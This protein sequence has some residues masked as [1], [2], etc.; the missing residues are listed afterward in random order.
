M[1]ALQE[2]MIMKKLK[3]YGTKL[4]PEEVEY[5]RKRKEKGKF[6]YSPEEREWL[7]KKWEKEWKEGEKEFLGTV[8]VSEKGKVEID[9]KDSRIGIIHL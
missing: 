9:A 6:I 1:N 2:I 8:Y 5:I 3:V 7:E 4:N